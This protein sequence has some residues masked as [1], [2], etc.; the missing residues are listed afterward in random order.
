MSDP[1]E[2]GVM[3]HYKCD[4]C[5]IRLHPPESRVDRIS[6]LCPECGS[7]LDPIADL[8]QLIGFRLIASQRDADRAAAFT[9]CLD[10]DE[11]KAAAI[12]LPP[13][14]TYL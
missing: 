5:R 14:E 12:A 13:P 2:R 11:P 4:A 1:N 10:P 8:A 9:D 7:P 3:P 6:D